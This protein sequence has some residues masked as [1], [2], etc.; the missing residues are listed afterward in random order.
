M[1]KFLLVILLV[2]VAFSAPGASYAAIAFDASS[3]STYTDLGATYNWPHTVTGTDPILL[4]YVGWSVA[5]DATT[6]SSVSYNSVA[7][8]RIAGSSGSTSGRQGEYWYLLCPA[9]G[10]HSISV[11]LSTAVDFQNSGAIS[12]TG[13]NAIGASSG[14]GGTASSASNSLTTTAANSYVVDGVIV[15]GSGAIGALSATGANQTK[16]F[17]NDNASAILQGDGSTKTTTTAG[18][19]TSTWTWDGSARDYGQSLVEVVAGTQAS[20]GA[21]TAPVASTYYYSYLL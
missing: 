1:R 5:G 7:L 18:S 11:T 8:T 4:V 2:A 19:Y 15:R 20:C 10:S 16:R 13:A 21:A 9:S 17:A 6:V 12:L 14:A 3:I